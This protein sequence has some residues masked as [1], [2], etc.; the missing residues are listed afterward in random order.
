MQDL[1]KNQMRHGECSV[2]GGSVSCVHRVLGNRERREC[3]M[4]TQTAEAIVQTCT[5]GIT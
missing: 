5:G 4:C 3:I 1:L 2:Q